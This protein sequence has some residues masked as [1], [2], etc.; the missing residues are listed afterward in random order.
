[1]RFATPGGSTCHDYNPFDGWRSISFWS[2][3]GSR[4]FR[5]GACD[6]RWSMGVPD[7]R[8]CTPAP[9]SSSADAVCE[10]GPTWRGDCSTFGLWVRLPPPAQ[11]HSI[12]C[13]DCGR[14]LD[15]QG[16]DCPAPMGVPC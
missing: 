9:E 8:D 16:C 13:Y 4:A 2:T 7:E 15:A 14:A 5:L 11:G 12:Y 6:L 1:M 10:P 3:V